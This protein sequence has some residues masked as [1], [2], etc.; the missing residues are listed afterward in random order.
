MAHTFDA[1]RRASLKSYV[2]GAGNT[3]PVSI[4]TPDLTAGKNT[5]Q[6]IDGVLLPDAMA[7]L[8]QAEGGT[9]KNG[10]LKQAGHPAYAWLWYGLIWLSVWV[11]VQRGS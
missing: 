6:I 1:Q 10:A 3:A 4:V 9:S 8:Q 11:A 5:V 2:Q 7:T